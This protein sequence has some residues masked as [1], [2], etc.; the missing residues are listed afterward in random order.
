MTL[1]FIVIIYIEIY[2]CVFGLASDFDLLKMSRSTIVPKKVRIEKTVY[3]Q[4]S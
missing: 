4:I 1:Y 3:K 2:M